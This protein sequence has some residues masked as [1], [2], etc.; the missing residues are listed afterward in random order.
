MGFRASN[1]Q[2]FSLPTFVAHLWLNSGK[3]EI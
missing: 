3:E 1:A 2:V